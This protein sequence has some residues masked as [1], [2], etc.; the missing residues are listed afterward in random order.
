MDTATVKNESTPGREFAELTAQAR[1]AY[2]EKR[3][4]ECIDITHRVLLA[5][6]GNAEA[7]ALHE[8]VQADIQ[9]DLNDARALLE[10]SRSM[11]DGQKYRKAAEIILLK[12]L[13]LDATHVEAKELLAVA[14]GTAAATIPMSTITRT[15]RLEETPFTASPKPVAMEPEPRGPGMSLKVPLIC[16]AV[17]V[18]AAG[19]WFFKS[20][21]PG[22]VAEAD[23]SISRAGESR[24][25]G[26]KT[27][28]DT[29]R[30]V[31]IAPTSSPA[32]ETALNAESASKTAS[33]SYVPPVPTPAKSVSPV[34]T[35]AL[36]VA[37][38]QASKPPVVTKAPGSLAVNSAIATDIYM[39][40]KYLGA[41][42]ATLPLP[43]GRQTIEY[44]HGD[45]RTVMTHEI[46]SGE[47]TT[48]FVTFETIVQINARP[49]A[50]VF[51]EG[52][53]RKSLGQTP[54]S[55]VRVPIGSVLTFENPA[56]PPKNYRVKDGESA[57]QVVFQ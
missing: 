15:T 13:Y 32:R 31:A 34:V 18:L 41:T 14:K 1:A 2:Q 20:R 35:A 21:V 4:K 29:R 54:L 42:P 25:A 36:P 27:S 49:W 7:N 19:I 3:T 26:L 23:T 16:V 50:Q 10:D 24:S 12:I 11:T 53:S 6:P 51:V 5:D 44:R 52:T 8:S 45:L 9:R 46:R 17:V 37:P 33:S 57:I 40:D 56:F 38:A 22:T 55:S 48:A 28:G 43:A 47:T 30:P 39:G